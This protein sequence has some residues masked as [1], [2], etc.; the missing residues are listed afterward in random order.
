LSPRL[1][2]L[3][4]EP[5]HPGERALAPRLPAFGRGSAHWRQFSADIRDRLARFPGRQ[6]SSRANHAATARPGAR[7]RR[8]KGDA[9][10]LLQVPCGRTQVARAR[11]GSAG[12]YLWLLPGG[13]ALPE[14]GTVSLKSEWQVVA[15]LGGASRAGADHAGRAAQRKRRAGLVRPVTI[16]ERATLIFPERRGYGTRVRAMERLSCRSAPAEA[17]PQSS[18]RGRCWM[19][20]LAKGFDAIGAGHV[21]DETLGRVQC[22]RAR[23]GLV[24]SRTGMTKTGLCDNSGEWLMPLSEASRAARVPSD[25][26]VARTHLS[27]HSNWQLAGCRYGSMSPRR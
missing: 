3:V 15:I 25:G 6:V 12:V 26:N 14:D 8:R 10:H 2:A 23:A 1:A 7:E 16:E 13:P 17:C 20:V 27:T 5:G 18:G 21:V 9:A 19:A 22:A 4:P 24:D 11:P